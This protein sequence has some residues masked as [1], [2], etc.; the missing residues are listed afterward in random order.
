MILMAYDPGRGWID[1]RDSNGSAASSSL[2]IVSPRELL[3]I[4]LSRG[5]SELRVGNLFEASVCRDRAEECAVNAGI[6][7]P[8]ELHDFHR[9]LNARLEK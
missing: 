7:I 5:G 1:E 2:R 3:M 9:T 8:P 4:Y 6:P